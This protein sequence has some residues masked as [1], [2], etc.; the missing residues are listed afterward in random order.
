MS[1]VVN[2]QKNFLNPFPILPDKL[3]V[4]PSQLL[5]IV[6]V[7]LWH[8]YIAS[9]ASV[10]SNLG[11]IDFKILAIKSQTDHCYQPKDWDYVAGLF[12]NLFRLLGK[13]R[14]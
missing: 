6:M 2:L 7:F 11:A 10:W 4:L 8:S 13:K 3:R 5:I 1:Q 12:M 9:F 14:A